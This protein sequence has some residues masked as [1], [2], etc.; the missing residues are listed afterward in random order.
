MS[1]RKRGPYAKTRERREAIA[2]AA[3]DLVNEQGHRSLGVAEVAERA[4]VTEATVTYHFPTR[5]QLLVAAIAASDAHD[6]DQLT[7]TREPHWDIANLVGESAKIGAEHANRLRLFV[8]M[9]SEAAVADHPAHEWLLTHHA[10]VR[11]NL[12][13]ALRMLQARGEAHPD[14]D[15]ERFARQMVAVWDGL[16]SQ[17]LVSPDFDLADEVA[18]AFRGLARQDV[19][20][21]RRAMEALAA[22]L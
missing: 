13:E 2:N 10:A 19:M 20:A 18:T 22:E 11:S 15:P 8:A 9:A 12:A 7:H 16:Q 14:I 6:E 5:D 3:L 4:G 21:A 17:W 1:G